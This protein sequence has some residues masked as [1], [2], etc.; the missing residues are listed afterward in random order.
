MPTTKSLIFT[1]L[2]RFKIISIRAE[3][4]NNQRIVTA[5]KSQVFH[6]SS[7]EKNEILT[8]KKII[9]FLEDLEQIV[10]NSYSQSIFFFKNQNYFKFYQLS[11]KFLCILIPPT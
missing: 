8:E 1:K 3:E 7:E 5:K 10:K 4:G 2:I 9:F 11:I 6:S